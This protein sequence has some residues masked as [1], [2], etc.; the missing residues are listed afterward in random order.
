MTQRMSRSEADFKFHISKS[1]DLPMLKVN[2]RFGAGINVEA[3]D[4]ASTTCAPQHMVVRMQRHQGQWIQCIRNGT[5]AADM[6]EMCV[7][8]PHVPNTPTALF[9][10]LQ[11][12]MTIP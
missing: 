9:R 4:R 5:C 6:V 7:R 2:S 1:Q 8:I 10:G 3:E 12:D 11:N